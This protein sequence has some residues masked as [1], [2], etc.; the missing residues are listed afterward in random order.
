MDGKLYFQAN[1]GMTGPELW[2]LDPAAT[3]TFPLAETQTNVVLAGFDEKLSASNGDQT[4]TYAIQ[5]LSGHNRSVGD[6]SGGCT[7]GK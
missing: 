3:C 7:T 4:G 6:G 2:V 1:D 5:S